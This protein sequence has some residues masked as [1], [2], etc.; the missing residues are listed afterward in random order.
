MT[1]LFPREANSI[2]RLVLVVLG[3]GAI[4]LPSFFVAWARTPFVTR[5]QDVMDQP[6]EFDHRHHV[7]DDGIACRYCHYEAWRSRYAGVP[8][9]Q[10]C[11]GCHAQVYAESARL[12]P[13]RASYFAKNPIEWNRVHRLPDYVYFDHAAHVTRG[14]G[15]EACHGAVDTMARVYVVAPLTM[16]WCLDCHRHPNEHVGHEAQGAPYA[17]PVNCSACHR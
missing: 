13:V 11:M 2:A 9:T 4:G 17:P 16:N 12:A 15:C 6:I 7:K 1:P 10:V 8:P 3:L 14:V 5:Q